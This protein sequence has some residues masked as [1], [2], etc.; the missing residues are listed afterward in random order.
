MVLAGS[1]ASWI[2]PDIDPGSQELLDVQVQ[3]D[4]PLTPFISYESMGSGGMVILAEDPG[5]IEI[6]GLI[7]QVSVKLVSSD[8]V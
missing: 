3:A 5:T 1:G 2:L 7:Y 8:D 4:A 6:A